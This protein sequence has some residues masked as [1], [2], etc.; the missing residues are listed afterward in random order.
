MAEWLSGTVRSWIGIG[1][2]VEAAE[3]SDDVHLS[4]VVSPDLVIGGTLTLRRDQLEA[5]PELATDVKKEAELLWRCAKTLEVIP[6][7]NSISHEN[8][9]NALGG[10]H[11]SVLRSGYFPVS[12]LTLILAKLQK[13]GILEHDRFEGRRTMWRRV[14]PE[15]RSK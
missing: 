9:L 3:G 1:V 15:S 2:Q 14:S 10:P 4:A 6:E 8:I 11:S 13:D 7:F 5:L 12:Q